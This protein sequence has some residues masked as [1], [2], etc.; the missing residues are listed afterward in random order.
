[1][2]LAIE[3]V[4]FLGDV[5]RDELIA[6]LLDLGLEDDIPLWEAG[7]DGEVLA[8]VSGDD[9]FASIGEALRLLVADDRVRVSEGHWRDEPVRVSLDRAMELVVDARWYQYPPEDHRVYYVNVLNL[10]DP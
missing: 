2:P 5:V 9:P 4:R 7:M 10:V 8:A 3:E 6:A 1:V